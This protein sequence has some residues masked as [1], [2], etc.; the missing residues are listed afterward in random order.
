[1]PSL[2]QSILL[3][4]KKHYSESQTAPK[5]MSQKQELVQIE[6]PRDSS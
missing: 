5:T 3:F 6:M 4:K 2:T 1:M